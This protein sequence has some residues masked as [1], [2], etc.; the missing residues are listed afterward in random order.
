MLLTSSISGRLIRPG[1]T[2][3]SASK[4][5]ISNFGL[6]VSY[7]LEKNVDVTV[8]EPGYIYTPF[9]ADDPPGYLTISSEKSVSDVLTHLGR[10]RVT[11]GSLLFDMY[12][13]FITMTNS[14]LTKTA[15]KARA[16]QTAPNFQEERKR[17]EEIV[18]RKKQ[19]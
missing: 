2:S 8:W 1:S 19:W 7:E 18:K 13:T 5:M 9:H 6:S 11:M 4:K 3:Y 17:K 10:S 14:A 12:P 15:M 16:E